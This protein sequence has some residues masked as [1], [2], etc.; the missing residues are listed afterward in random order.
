MRRSSYEQISLIARR[1]Q[2]IVQ[3]KYSPGTRIP[4]ER[5]WAKR[6]NFSHN[7]IHRAM[8]MLEEE[9]ILWSSGGRRGIFLVSTGP[10]SFRTRAQ[11]SLNFF[12]PFELSQSSHMYQLWKRICDI[13]HISHPTINIEIR[14]EQN[15]ADIHLT[16]PPL[17]DDTVFE[18]LPVAELAFD[19]ALLPGIFNAGELDRKCYGMPILQTPA[20][21]WGHR[22]ILAKND[23][24]TPDFR[25]PLD[26]FRWG[27]LL[28]HVRECASGFSF[29]GFTYHVCQWGG[30]IRRE[31]DNF[32]IAPEPLQ[33]FFKELYDLVPRANLPY[34]PYPNSH[35]FHRGQQAL[36][37]DYL[38]SLPL[39]EHRFVL[40]GMPLRENGFAVHTSFMLSAKK[41][42]PY[43]E[44]IHEFMRFCLSE[45]VQKLFFL[46]KAHFSVRKSL[47]EQQYAE[48]SET[49][50]VCIP[51]YDP[52][53][54]F[55]GLYAD[56][57]L[58][59]SAF[60]YSKCAECLSHD[61]RIDL[62]VEQIQCVNISELRRQWLF[63]TP[64]AEKQK[65]IAYVN[66]I[67]ALA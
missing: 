41:N 67:S 1:I 54:F 2:L 23:L 26:F 57:W 39:T 29:Y 9:G 55:P 27:N 25:D 35:F 48:L 56:F 28:N 49:T 33:C 37:A 21:F 18:E 10:K 65:V 11:G 13:F 34:S 51:P 24:F 19:D 63:R 58:P 4:A 52:R 61:T 7:R 42:T 59:G 31:G 53:G 16:W 66:K 6:L 50:S 38:H 43:I 47:Y 20:C 17:L 32:L 44:E 36:V 5:F 8:Q 12:L 14:A 62:A 30:E 15:T 45:S 3:K 40:L 64:E 46:P 60:Y 22:N